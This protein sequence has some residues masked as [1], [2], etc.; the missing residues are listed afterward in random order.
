MLFSEAT[1]KSRRTRE[2]RI[3]TFERKTGNGISPSYN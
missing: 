2:K 3:P 1:K